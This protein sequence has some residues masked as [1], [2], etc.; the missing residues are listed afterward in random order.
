[1]VLHQSICLPK[2]EIG[3]IANRA[4]PLCYESSL[5]IFG[6]HSFIAAAFFTSWN[7]W[8]R[9]YSESL[10]NG[11]ANF[12]RLISFSKIHNECSA[13]LEVAPRISVASKQHHV[14]FTFHM[15]Q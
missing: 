4:H 15:A 12:L 7:F 13:M 3:G 10:A 9:L 11:A 5:K 1:M 6:A 14:F 2:R 8:K